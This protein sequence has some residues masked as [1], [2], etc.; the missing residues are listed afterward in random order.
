MSWSSINNFLANLQKEKGERDQP[1]PDRECT[2]KSMDR[3][4][5]LLK[6]R[7]VGDVVVPSLP[8]LL[9]QLNGDAAHGAPLQP[10]HQVGDKPGNLIVISALA[11][12]PG[13]SS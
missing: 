9:L 8:L 12:H 2:G 1:Y 13:I 3:V 11:F 7:D 10:L 6:G 4:L 5:H